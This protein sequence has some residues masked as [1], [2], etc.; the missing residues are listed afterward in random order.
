MIEFDLLIWEGCWKY[1]GFVDLIE[2]M[3]FIIKN[4]M[5]DL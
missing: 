3:K 1:F 4:E 5:I 2:G